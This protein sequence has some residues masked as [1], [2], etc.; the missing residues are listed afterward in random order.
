MAFRL[1]MVQDGDCGLAKPSQALKWKPFGE[2]GGIRSSQAV[3]HEVRTTELNIIYL[4]RLWIGVRPECVFLML[5]LLFHES[6]YL[7]FNELQ[8]IPNTIK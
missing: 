3:V 4:I 8:C 5:S 1:P 2:N 7:L 6:N